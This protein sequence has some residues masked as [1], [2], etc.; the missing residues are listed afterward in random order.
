MQR[1]VDVCQ[2]DVKAGRW[3]VLYGGMQ[4]DVYS[5]YTINPV[6]AAHDRYLEGDVTPHVVT[7]IYATLES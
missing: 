2:P 3:L 6:D 5:T 4:Y 1:Y 7:R